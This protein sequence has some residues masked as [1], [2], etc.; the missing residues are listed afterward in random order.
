MNLTHIFEAIGRSVMDRRFFLRQ[1]GTVALFT[2]I[3][4]W[5][6]RKSTRLNSSHYS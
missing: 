2:G 5:G 4:A 3:P 1:L 6:D